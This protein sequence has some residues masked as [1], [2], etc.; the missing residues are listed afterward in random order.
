MDVFALPATQTHK[1]WQDGI[2]MKC[3]G[4]SERI[5]KSEYLNMFK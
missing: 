1:V 3:L 2:R 5:R 4:E